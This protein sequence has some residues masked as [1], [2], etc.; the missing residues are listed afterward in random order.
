MPSKS[1]TGVAWDETDTVSKAMRVMDKATPLI[2][3]AAALL[4]FAK[5]VMVYVAMLDSTTQSLMLTQNIQVNVMAWNRL[6]SSRQQQDEGVQDQQLLRAVEEQLQ[7]L[8]RNQFEGRFSN[9]HF[10]ELMILGLAV[11]DIAAIYYKITKAWNFLQSQEVADNKKGQMMGKFKIW[12]SWMVSCSFIYIVIGIVSS[13]LHYQFGDDYDGDEW[14]M[15]NLTLYFWVIG[16]IY[17]MLERWV[18]ELMKVVSESRPAVT[19]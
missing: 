18:R 11:M 12:R 3:T 10:L 8:K 14:T 17:L 19:V 15:M 16:G 2:L 7:I 1:S 5:G 9:I 6:N 13:V 4:F